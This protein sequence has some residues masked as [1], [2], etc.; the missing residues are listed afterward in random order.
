MHDSGTG[1]VVTIDLEG[2]YAAR[3]VMDEVVESMPEFGL[4]ELSLRTVF[5]SDDVP[6]Y[7]AGVPGFLALQDPLDYAQTHHSQADTF[8]RVR[9]EDLQQGADILALWA[10]HVAQLSGMMPRQPQPRKKR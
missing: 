8:D 6:F 3:E 9:K 4:L 5:G 10:Y 7:E 1:K 2:D